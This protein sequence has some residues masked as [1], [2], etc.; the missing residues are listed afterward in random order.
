MAQTYYINI[1]IGTEDLSK[2]YK[3]TKTIIKQEEGPNL[4]NKKV[5]LRE[6]IEKQLKK[7]GINQLK[8]CLVT[9]D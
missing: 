1:G 6:D 9:N 4:I 5:S 7:N 8:Y 3:E 2:F